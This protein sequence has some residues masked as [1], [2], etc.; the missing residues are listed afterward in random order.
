MTPPGS[1]VKVREKKFSYFFSHKSK[2]HNPK[3]L[4]MG[5]LPAAA[6]LVAIAHFVRFMPCL[7]GCNVPV[8]STTYPPDVNG[9]VVIPFGVTSIPSCAYFQCSAVKSVSFPSSGLSSIGD[10]AFQQT[11]LQTV[12]IPGSCTSIGKD[13]FF[14]H[15]CSLQG[16]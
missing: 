6:F 3:T 4:I 16:H 8:C 15:L 11:S 12:D 5:I 9:N 13:A 10:Q 1:G 14:R 7:G 2:I